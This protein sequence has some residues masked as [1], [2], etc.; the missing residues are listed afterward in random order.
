MNTIFARTWEVSLWIWENK[1]WLFS[2]LLVPLTIYLVGLLVPWLKA[3]APIWATSGSRFHKTAIGVIVSLLILIVFCRVGCSPPPPCVIC[4]EEIYDDPPKRAKELR[5]ILVTHGL[6]NRDYQSLAATQG[7]LADPD[8]VTLDVVNDRRHDVIVLLRDISLPRSKS[9]E[10]SVDE[11]KMIR[12]KAGGRKDDVRMS[13]FTKALLPG[14]A[15]RTR[16]YSGDYAVFVI[17][18][19]R[20]TVEASASVPVHRLIPPADRVADGHG[21]RV[22]RVLARP[23]ENKSI[24]RLEDPTR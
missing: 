15:L 16:S 6:E 17:D 5:S 24:V 10:A 3:R 12:V 9:D 7:Q 18:C 20:C 14:I 19:S 21:R 11:W 2:G 13:P 22:L 8:D 1:E 4:T 23:D